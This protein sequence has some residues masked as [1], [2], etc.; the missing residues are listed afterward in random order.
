[1]GIEQSKEWYDVEHH[2]WDDE[3]H[4]GKYAAL[5]NTVVS[6]LRGWGSERVLDIGCGSGYMTKMIT[7]T[8]IE[9]HA[10]DFSKTSVL[11]TSERGISDVWLGNCLDP[12]NYLKAD[13]DAYVSTEVL[14]HIEE[15][16]KI[17]EN[18]PSGK[19]FVFSVPSFD[20]PG[21]VRYFLE[22]SQVVERYLPF[23]EIEKILLVQRDQTVEEVSVVDSRF[24][25]RYVVQGTVK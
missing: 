18:I 25:A 20:S 19:P 22:S 10:F 2:E 13:Y 24:A 23:I 21:H 7:D 8:G 6:T 11:M 9:C 15:D 4:G 5:F 1:M 16:L 14:E 17:F 12:E 3:H